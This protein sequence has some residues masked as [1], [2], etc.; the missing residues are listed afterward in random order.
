MTH[1][2]R[3]LVNNGK[4]LNRLTKDF[5]DL[6]YNI[7]TYGKTVRELEKNEHIVVIVKAWNIRKV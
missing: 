5:R 1:T 7:I 6:G 2:T 3:Y 4:D